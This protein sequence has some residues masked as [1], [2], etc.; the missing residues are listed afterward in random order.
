MA[1]RKRGEEGGGRGGKR[2][3]GGAE[4]RAKRVGEAEGV[5]GGRG[6][7]GKKKKRGILALKT[8][9][10]RSRAE[11]KIGPKQLISFRRACPNTTLMETQSC[12][13]WDSLNADSL[14]EI[15]KV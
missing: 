12:I 8:S 10:F 5:G 11:K 14:N 9:I 1:G 7:R 4:R 3:G 13:S 15:S 6:G 2:E